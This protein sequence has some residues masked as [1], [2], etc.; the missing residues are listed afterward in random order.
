MACISL[1]L[2]IFKL[3]SKNYFLKNVNSHN[4]I[5]ILLKNVVCMLLGAKYQSNDS[6]VIDNFQLLF[7]ITDPKI[8]KLLVLIWKI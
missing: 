7:L 3:K 1:F 5:L 4:I 2:I 6:I 8:T